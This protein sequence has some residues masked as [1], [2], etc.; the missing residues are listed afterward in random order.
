MYSAGKVRKASDSGKKL[1]KMAKLKSWGIKGTIRMLNLSEPDT[2]DEN[3][4]DA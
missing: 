1:K 4:K 3:T 2:E